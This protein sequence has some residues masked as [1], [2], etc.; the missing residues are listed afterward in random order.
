M[1]NLRQA[2]NEHVGKWVL[3]NT[4]SGAYHGKIEK[5]DRQGVTILVP[6]HYKPAGPIRTVAKNVKTKETLSAAQYYY[7]YPYGGYGCP[8]GGCGYAR[9][10]I[11]FWWLLALG[12]LAWW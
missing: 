6:S 7:G 3:L 4:R 9:W 10:W 1:K 8:Y 2:A 5:V 11:P 12:L